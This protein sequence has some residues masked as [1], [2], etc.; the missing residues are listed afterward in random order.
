MRNTQGLFYAGAAA[1]AAIFFARA[2]NRF[3]TPPPAMALLSLPPRFGAALAASNPAA[4]AAGGPAGDLFA[5]CDEGGEGG[6]GGRQPVM[7]PVHPSPSLPGLTL[8]LLAAVAGSADTSRLPLQLLALGAFAE[9]EGPAGAAGG[10]VRELVV[11]TSRATAADVTLALRAAVDPAATAAPLRLP[12]RV[13]EEEAVLHVA[14]GSGTAGL[15]PRTTTRLLRLLAARHVATEHY[16]VMDGAALLAGPLRRGDL[17]HRRAGGDGG[18]E[19]VVDALPRWATPDRWEATE[20]L[21]RADEH[22]CP[23]A[24]GL[25]YDR[26]ADAAYTAVFDS[27]GAA[28]SLLS[29]AAVRATVCRLRRLHPAPTPAPGAHP[30]AAPATSGS[31]HAGWLN[32]LYMQAWMADVHTRPKGAGERHAWT[33]ETL[34]WVA[35]HCEPRRGGAGEGNVWDSVLRVAAEGDTGRTLLGLP[36]LAAASSESWWPDW[37]AVRTVFQ[38]PCC[39]SSEGAWEGWDV[40]AAL[41]PTRRHAFVTVPG[42]GSMGGKGGWA[43]PPADVVAAVMTPHILLAAS[44]EAGRHSG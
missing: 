35:A 25:G 9:P 1:L 13:V 4:A 33:A 6:A 15:P 7:P 5:G 21:L 44:G 38:A 12:F 10:G 36:A 41:A 30:P 2:L 43:G 24:G 37:A 42:G 22:G 28:L 3:P 39:P 31:E 19:G 27:A 29:R 11:L 40:A 32:A 23:H 8:V 26:G 34:V 16:V 14:H 18:W 17:L 20:T